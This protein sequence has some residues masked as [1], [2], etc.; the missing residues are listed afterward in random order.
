MYSYKREAETDEADTHR[1]GVYMAMG[2]E[3]PLKEA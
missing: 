1:G 3:I 2:A